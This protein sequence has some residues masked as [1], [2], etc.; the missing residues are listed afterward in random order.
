[1]PSI[2]V[3][4][5][6][7]E[8]LIGFLVKRAGIVVLIAYYSGLGIWGIARLPTAFIPN[9]TK[10]NAMIAVQLPRRRGARRTVNSLNETTRLLSRRRA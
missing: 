2:I 3:L 5:T 10:A 8:G 9:E 4:E 1:M 6:A 7:Y